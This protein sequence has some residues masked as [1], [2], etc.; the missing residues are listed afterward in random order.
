MCSGRACRLSAF[1][2]R[3]RSP[4]TRLRTKIC[5]AGSLRAA[6][7]WAVQLPALATARSAS[8][9]LLASK[10]SGTAIRPAAPPLAPRLSTAERGSPS[11]GAA[12]RPQAARAAVHAAQATRQGVCKCFVG[13]GR[14]RA[15]CHSGTGTPSLKQHMTRRM[16]ARPPAAVASPHLAGGDAE[17]LL[18]HFCDRMMPLCEKAPKQNQRLNH[19][20]PESAF[21]FFFVF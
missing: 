10:W 14:R 6:R 13:P 17:Q 20:K 19:P 2:A 1:V 15:P 12:P 16:N 3:T 9:R 8:Q 4:H 18:P 7:M 5:S 11:P 21:F